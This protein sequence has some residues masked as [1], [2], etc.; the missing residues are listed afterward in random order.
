MPP[1]YS[2]FQSYFVPSNT[3][4]YIPYVNNAYIPSD[5]NMGYYG[6][7]Q[8]RHNNK[9]KSQKP[10]NNSN[11]KYINNPQY[12]NEVYNQPP[13]VESVVYPPENGKQMNNSVVDVVSPGSDLSSSA[14]VFV[15]TFS[16]PLVQPAMNDLNGIV[17]DNTPSFTFE[18]VDTETTT[19]IGVDHVLD[20]QPLTFTNDDYD[21]TVTEAA[22]IVMDQVSSTPSSQSEAIF[23]SIESITQPI[24]NSE[25]SESPI[26]PVSSIDSETNF[27]NQ[28]NEQN[29]N[30]ETTVHAE[31]TDRTLNEP[32]PSAVSNMN[33][34]RQDTPP[35][36]KDTLTSTSRSSYL[37]EGRNNSSNLSKNRDGEWTKEKIKKEV[38][39][40]LPADKAWR[41][42]EQ[43]PSS[44]VS[45]DDGIIRYEKMSMME[46]FVRHSVPPES[47]R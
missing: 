10:Y 32:S 46:M 43:P 2:P 20:L 27:D 8:T 12:P 22:S 37:N 42:G 39:S 11:N 24:L 19:T 14:P 17:T 23:K 30:I 40:V 38:E 44:F 9:P 33:S 41:R 6:T 35:G 13:V 31:N 21:V 45:K 29:N 25:V 1:M 34:P 26:I 5:Q 36:F 16:L 7:Q 18:S 4:S 3:Y 47:L 28:E 15:P